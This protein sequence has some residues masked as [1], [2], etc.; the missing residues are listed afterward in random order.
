M[1]ELRETNTELDK[2]RKELEDLKVSYNGEKK[3]AEGETIF[4]STWMPRRRI[5]ST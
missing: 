1:D 5:W 2:V 4:F 3:K